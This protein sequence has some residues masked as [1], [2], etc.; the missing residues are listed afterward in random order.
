MQRPI[1]GNRCLFGGNNQTPHKGGSEERKRSD[2]LK[3]T[4]RENEL[5]SS[6][7]SSPKLTTLV[8]KTAIPT[9]HSSTLVSSALLA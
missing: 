8:V 7:L 3:S 2:V 1:G 5:S 4:K 6:D 9:T